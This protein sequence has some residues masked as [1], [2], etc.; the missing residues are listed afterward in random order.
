M[1]CQFRTG[2]LSLLIP[3]KVKKLVLI[4]RIVLHGHYLEDIGACSL[5]DALRVYTLTFSSVSSS[6]STCSTKS[7]ALKRVMLY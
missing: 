3:S 7:D 2:I 1:L 5:R 6:K 4:L